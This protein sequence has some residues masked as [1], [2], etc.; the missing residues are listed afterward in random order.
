MEIY[1]LYHCPCVDGVFSLLVLCLFFKYFLIKND[2]NFTAL[3]EL[4]LS[5]KKFVSLDEKETQIQQNASIME[6]EKNE[7]IKKNEE[8]KELKEK[9]VIDE[10]FDVSP[11]S[12]SKQ[13]KYFAIQ[14]SSNANLF[15][16]FM[17]YM[18][19]SQEP[20][21]IIISLDYYCESEDNI[22]ILSACAKK[23]IIIDH[24]ESLTKFDLLSVKNLEIFFDIKK[25]GA[26]LALD[27]FTKLMGDQLIPNSILQKLNNFL[28][29]VQDQ[30]LHTGLFKETE[31]FISGLLKFKNDMNV[32]KNDILFNKIF[33]FSPETY[34]QFGKPLVEQ[35]HILVNEYF[36]SRKILKVALS[37]GKQ[38]V[39][40]ACKISD[41]A[42]IND[43]G[44]KLAEEGLKNNFNNIG[45]VYRNYK[46]PNLFKISVRGSNKHEDGSCMELANYWGGGGHK[47]AAGCFLNKKKFNKYFS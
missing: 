18:K 27:Y 26:T 21:K 24:H 9:I 6:E 36:K 25:S 30:D 13:I 17:R 8:I 22:K 46:D 7:D 19:K 11:G 20:D 15:S 34:I 37:N 33:K 29:Y 38:I 4:L 5:E 32:Y 40:F 2:S 41:N 35:K 10:E 42:V 1:V 44:E 14:P 45:V 31:A 39:C 12:I 47:Y 3:F 28:L 23:L 16:D 43:L